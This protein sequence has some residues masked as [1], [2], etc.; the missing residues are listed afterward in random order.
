[1]PAGGAGFLPL[2]IF[3]EQAGKKQYLMWLS[4]VLR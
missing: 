1:M 2:A 3:I 4:V